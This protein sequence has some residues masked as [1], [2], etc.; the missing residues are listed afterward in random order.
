MIGIEVIDNNHLY[1][2]V[3]V[4]LMNVNKHVSSDFIIDYLK[5]L[6]D[7]ITIIKINVG[8]NLTISK[9]EKNMNFI[10]KL[11]FFFYSLEKN[12]IQSV[13]LNNTPRTFKTI[14][15]VLKP[16]LTKNALQMISIEEH[17]LLIMLF[18]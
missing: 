13:E 4:L 14:F 11:C 10:K 5:K 7:D 2:D 8:K 15:M 3:C 18:K 12:N 9:V 6:M 17:F 1:I 16:L